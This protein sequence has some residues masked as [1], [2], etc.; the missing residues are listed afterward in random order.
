MCGGCQCLVGILTW[1]NLGEGQP[2]EGPGM[3]G[4]Q[5]GRWGGPRRV[6]ALVQVRD[7][8]GLD[9]SGDCGVGGGSRAGGRVG[10]ESMMMPKC[11]RLDRRNHR[12][13]HISSL[14][15]KAGIC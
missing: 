14:T 7:D 8:T 3:S 13:P 12:I 9:S 4:E 2:G 6:F 5:K 1:R 15:P 10:E 11:R